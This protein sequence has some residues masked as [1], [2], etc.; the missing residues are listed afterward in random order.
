MGTAGRVSRTDEAEHGL[1]AADEEDLA[2]RLHHE[3]ILDGR[4]RRC[5]SR[6]MPSPAASNRAWARATTTVTCTAEDKAGNVGTA[7]EVRI[8]T[9]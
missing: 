2:G 7:T 3:M 1:S 4:P 6:S 5:S 9:L 8:V